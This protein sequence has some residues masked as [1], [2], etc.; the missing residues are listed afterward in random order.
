LHDP[1]AVALV[2]AGT[3]DEIPFCDWDE[4]K[5]GHPK[6]EERF[7]VTVV[8]EGTLEE[9]ISGK[10]QTGRTIAK[11]LPPGSRGVRI[12]RGCNTQKFWDV[13]EE[14]MQRADALNT[15]LQR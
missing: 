5:S 4:K 8:T 10:T 12:P 15:A 2:L 7:E 1:L 6:H 14:C 9:A 13:I 11:V 3:C